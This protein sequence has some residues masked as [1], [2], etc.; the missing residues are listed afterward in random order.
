LKES[1]EFHLADRAK[2]GMGVRQEILRLSAYLIPSGEV[3]LRLT[4]HRGF[5]LACRRAAL[6]IRIFALGEL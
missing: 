1:D 6:R 5:A 4:D 2:T 3:Q